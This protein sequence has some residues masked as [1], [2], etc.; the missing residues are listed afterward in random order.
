MHYIP[1]YNKTVFGGLS[2]VLKLAI[3]YQKK[4]KM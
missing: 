2:V 1:N 4:K 3:F